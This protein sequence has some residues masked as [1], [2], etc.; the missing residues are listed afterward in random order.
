LI[1]YWLGVFLQKL[2]NNFDSKRIALDKLIDEVEHLQREN[3]Q[4]QFYVK[5]GADDELFKSIFILRNTINIS[6][7]N[8]ID[9]QQKIMEYLN[10][11][12]IQSQLNEKVQKIK[13]LKDKLLL[14]EMT[15]FE[16]II[17]ND[18]SYVFQPNQIFFTKLSIP[19]LQNE[20]NLPI[21]LKVSNKNL[22]K[23]LYKYEEITEEIEDQLLSISE[24]QRY[25]INLERFKQNF[26]STGGN[27]I[28]FILDYNFEN[29]LDFKDKITLYCKVATTFNN[30]FIIINEYQEFEN[31]EFAII[32]PK[33]Q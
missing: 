14:K 27:L 19:F 23:K 9:I 33:K 32:K 5:T 15:N 7:R 16:E 12:K 3:Q 17:K 2:L 6:R 25:V 30:D 8:L 10:Q 29:Q 20:N 22:K 31:I 13:A 18:N 1:Y 11:I 21:L 4:W 26:I 24:K 28:D